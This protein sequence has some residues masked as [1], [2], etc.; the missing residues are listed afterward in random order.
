[1]RAIIVLIVIFVINFP[2]CHGQELHCN[3]RNNDTF[4]YTCDLKIN[5]PDGLNNFTG[6]SGE[7]LSEMSDSDIRRILS[8]TGSN[9]TNV[10]SIICKTFMNV[11]RIELLSMRISNI[12]E[13][14]FKNCRFLKHLDLKLN[15]I[16]IIHEKSF[17]YNTELQTLYLWYNQLTTLP[18]NVFSSQ[19]KLQTLW[20][21]YNKIACPPKNVFDPL[22]GLTELDWRGNQIRNLTVEWFEKLENLKSLHFRANLIEELPKNVFNSLKK[23]TS[24]NIDNNRLKIINSDSFGVLPKFTQINLSYN[25]IDAVDEM[26]V[27][28][29]GLVLIAFGYNKCANVSII[30]KTESRESMRSVLQ[31]C[32]NNFKN[33]NSGEHLFEF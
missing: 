20:I 19:Q 27:D 33:L 28:N 7:H 23:M 18:E 31:D 26:I 12:D 14:S 22:K 29:T 32:F 8:A 4:G 1:M 10:P 21:N 6:I 13:N 9:S 17:N 24:L 25:Q 3:F 30:D 15:Q 5:N 16:K 11:T 2:P